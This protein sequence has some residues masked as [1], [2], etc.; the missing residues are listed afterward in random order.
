MRHGT[1]IA[2]ALGALA[3]QRFVPMTQID[4][5]AAKSAFADQHGGFGGGQ[6]LAGRSGIDHHPRQPRRQRQLPQ[7][8]A[9]FGHAAIGVDGAEFGEQRFRFGK[10]RPRRRIE[11]SEFVRRGAP[12]GE[13]ERER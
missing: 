7:Q 4:V 5:V 12:G 2:A 10:R 8:P 3:A 6:C 11:E 9:C 13:I 1:R